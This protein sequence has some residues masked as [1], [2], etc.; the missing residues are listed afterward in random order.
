MAHVISKSVEHELEYGSVTAKCCMRR[1]AT[2]TKVQKISH[3]DFFPTCNTN[4]CDVF[5]KLLRNCKDFLGK[6][7]EL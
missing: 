1:W 4:I 7:M 5:H 6:M 2:E 3:V